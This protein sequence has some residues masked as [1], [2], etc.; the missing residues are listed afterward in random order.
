MKFLKYEHS[1]NVSHTLKTVQTLR[2]FAEMLE[3]LND[4]LSVRKTINFKFTLI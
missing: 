4:E 2:L 3:T 1:K